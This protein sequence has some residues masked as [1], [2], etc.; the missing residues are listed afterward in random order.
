[1]KAFRNVLSKP[2]IGVPIN[3]RVKN[4]VT[5]V[6]DG[7]WRCIVLLKIDGRE[8][9]KLTSLHKDYNTGHGDNIYPINPPTHENRLLFISSM[10]CGHRISVFMLVHEMVVSNLS[11]LRSDIAH[12]F[13]HEHL[14]LQVRGIL[15]EYMPL[16]DIDAPGSSARQPFMSHSAEGT[17][18]VGRTKEQQL[19]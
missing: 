17:Y 13:M 6:E 5:H 14:N 9:V 4:F 7:I 15:A 1:M 3:S 2:N 18:A 19:V 10:W 16:E 12:V 8:Q 11:L